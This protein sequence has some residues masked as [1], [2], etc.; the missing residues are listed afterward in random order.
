MEGTG[1]IRFPITTKQPEAQA[2]FNQGVGQLH[3]FWYY[4]SERSFRQVAALDPDCAMAYWGMAMSNLGNEKRAKP[5]IEAAVKRE[6]KVT[7]RERQY[8]QAVAQYLQSNDSSEQRRKKIVEAWEN[9]VRKNPEDIESRAFLVWQLFDNH[10]NKLPIQSKVAVNSLISDVLRI[11]PLHPVHHYRIHITNPGDDR[12]L[13]FHAASRCGQTAPSIPHMWHMPGHTF[14]DSGRY[15]DG[16]WYQE[17]ALRVEH[18]H[19]TRMQMMPDETSLFSHNRGWLIDN[20]SHVGR[21]REAIDLCKHMV[22][23][24]RQQGQNPHEGRRKLLELLVRHERWSELAKLEGTDYL[25]DDEDEHEVRRLIGLT[26]A[27]F[28]LGKPDKAEAAL[29]SI[30]KARTKARTDRTQAVAEAE[31]KARKDKKSDADI[32]KARKEAEKKASESINRWEKIDTEIRLIR[33]AVV[34]DWKAVLADLEK[35]DLPSE[36]KVALYLDAGEME[37]AITASGDTSNRV[38]RLAIRAW[39]FHRAKKS[40][41][42]NK[43][44]DELRIL[45]GGADLDDPCL[46]RLEPLIAELKL[47]ADWRTPKLSKDVGQ[48]PEIAK[49]GP[50]R[51]QPWQA[52]DWKLPQV[53][54]KDLTLRSYRGKPVIVICYLGFGCVHCVRQLE[55]FAPLK[56]KYAKEG[57]EVVAISTDELAAMQESSALKGPKHEL[58][59][60]ILADPQMT[61]FKAYRAFDDFEKRPLHATF[62]IDGAGRVRWQD[63]GPEPF[64]NAEFLLKESKRLLA[65]PEERLT[66]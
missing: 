51:W 16:A 15:A 7:P 60:A 32:A 13:A 40:A 45:A 23:L 33:A 2:F 21:V 39:V 43:A 66:P 29:A 34:K 42:A 55:T 57:I 54:A 28:A 11:Q 44:M 36:R 62:L 6:G 46:R 30:E 25:A 35:A 61:V 41:E 4:E 5:F 20:L 8:I 59:F 1:N 52:P 64:T 50:F 47:P 19:M 18:L 65:I 12:E 3:G 63:V 31:A 24:P 37:K 9:I 49:L 56:D 26:R 58:P 22:D 27:W 17:A 48:R 38:Y 53:G 10:E 14:S